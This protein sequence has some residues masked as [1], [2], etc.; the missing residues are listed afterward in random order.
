MDSSTTFVEKL[1][2]ASRAVVGVFSDDEKTNTDTHGL[3][4]ALFPTDA[5]AS[6]V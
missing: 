6:C 1:K 5:V 4:N 2:A 3:L